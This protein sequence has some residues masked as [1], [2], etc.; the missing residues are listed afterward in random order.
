MKFYILGHSRGLGEYLHKN[1]N[2][3]GFSRPEFNIETDIELIVNKIDNDSVV[4]LNAY[5]GGTQIEYLNLLHYRTSVIVCGSI[6]STFYDPDMLEYSK[7]KE[8]LEKRFLD[9]STSNKYPMLYLK[10]TSSSYKDYSLI[11]RTIDFW[12]D[13]PN[14]T[15]AG[16]NIKKEIK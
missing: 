10:L 9:L 15:F 4:I 14:F 16:F 12:L 2:A 8:I 3:V 7:N 6:A 5:A 11:K 1:F 13:N